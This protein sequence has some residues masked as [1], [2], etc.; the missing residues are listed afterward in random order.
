MVN[1]HAVTAVALAVA[2]IGAVV[3]GVARLSPW[4]LLGWP[5]AWV[6][7]AALA[8]IVRADAEPWDDEPDTRGDAAPT[9]ERTTR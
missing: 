7:L 9:P 2:G 1:T 6:A 8:F 4:L 5:C 3:I